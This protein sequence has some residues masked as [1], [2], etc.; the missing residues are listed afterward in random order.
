MRSLLKNRPWVRRIVQQAVN[1]GA[2]RRRILSA[3]WRLRRSPAAAAA[4]AAG[5]AIAG[6]W[7][8]WVS[9]QSSD[10]R[11]LLLLLDDRPPSDVTS[12]ARSSRQPRLVADYN[13]TGRKEDEGGL[14]V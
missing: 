6:H 10:T 14:P 1:I 2:G 4:A 9:T 7:A 5:L 8:V 11:C 13:G 3:V 12:L